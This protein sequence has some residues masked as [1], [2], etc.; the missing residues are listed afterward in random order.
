MF[1]EGD[2]AVR[3][4]DGVTVEL[5]DAAG[6]PRSWGRRARASPRSCTAW[7]G[8]TGRPRA[9][10]WSTASTSATLDDA[11]LTEL[12]RDKFGFVFQFFNLLPVLTAEEN[13][14]LPLKLAGR[15]ARPRAAAARWSTPSAS[16]TG[17]ATGPAELSGGQQ[18]RV[19]IARALMLQAGGR[20]RRRADRQP[21]LEVERRGA[22]A[23]AP[24]RRRVRPDG[25]DGHP[26]RAGGRDR[27]PRAGAGRRPD[28]PRREADERRAGARPDEAAA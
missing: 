9:R 17:S 25:R 23:A 27:R 7:P 4:L 21:R 22:G 10:S 28:R 11:K 6:S 18:Q 24:R 15:D 1:G 5:P 12:R 16:A 19:A 13:I 8:S 14:L 20:L 26:R 2:A 3:A